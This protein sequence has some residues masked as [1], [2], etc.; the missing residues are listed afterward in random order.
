MQLPKK[1]RIRV[2]PETYSKMRSMVFDSQGWRCAK[3]GQIKPLTLDHKIKRSQLGS[4]E[5]ENLQGLCVFCHDQKDNAAKSK[6]SYWAK[7]SKS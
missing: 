5:I 7:P 2:D 3:C 6:S 1:V 4:D